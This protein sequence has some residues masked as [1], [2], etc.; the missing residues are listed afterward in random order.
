M[1]SRGSVLAGRLPGCSLWF[2]RRRVRLRVGVAEG[3]IEAGESESGRRIP[4][5]LGDGQAD[6]VVQLE[7]TA[8]SS[9]KK[10]VRYARVGLLVSPT[11]RR[12][13]GDAATNTRPGPATTDAEQ[14]NNHDL[15]LEHE[16]SRGAAAHRAGFA[17]WR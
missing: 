10:V 7:R 5:R 16:R 17:S 1:L 2:I 13:S 9:R 3:A 8:I 6:V 14:H 12:A 15:Q 4:R 11:P